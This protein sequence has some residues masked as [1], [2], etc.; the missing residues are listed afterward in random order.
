MEDLLVVHMSL[1]PVSHVE[2]G[3]ERPGAAMVVH[4]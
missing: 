4:L 3:Q 2:A 1:S